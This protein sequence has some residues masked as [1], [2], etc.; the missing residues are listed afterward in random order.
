MRISRLL[1]K[2]SQL[3]AGTSM[4][5]S[6][7]SDTDEY[8]SVCALAAG[9]EQVFATFRQMDA[10]TNILE[11][12]TYE[13]G[14]SYLGLTSESLVQELV[15]AFG[16]RLNQG[17]PKTFDFGFG[18]DISPSLLRYAK[19]AS[20]LKQLFGPIEGA[21]VCEVGGGYGGQALVISHA[22]KPRSYTI[23]DLPEPL[24]LTERWLGAFPMPTLNSLCAFDLARNLDALGPFDLFVSNY[25]FS[26]IERE[27][28]NRLLESVVTQSVRGY[29]TYN[30]IGGSSDIM[31]AEEFRQRVGG[32]ILDENPLTHRDNCIVIWGD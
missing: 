13:Q 15:S 19:V 24:L 6:S 1:G 32:R 31:S 7:I 8:R 28:Q 25:A 18:M 27:G 12:V 14:L 23:V 5:T 4:D 16:S 10:Y 26:E 17:G 9:N 3:F 22:F 21:D 20:D 30:H 11:H 2:I 29:V